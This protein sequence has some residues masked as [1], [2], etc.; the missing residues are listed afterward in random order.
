MT[1]HGTLL[2]KGKKSIKR[3]SAHDQKGSRDNLRAKYTE[4][5]SEVK[6]SIKQIKRSGRRTLLM[7]QK[8][9][10]RANNNK[11]YLHDHNKV[12]QY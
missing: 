4:K 11:L 8:K 10:Q 5:D 7:K 2:T 3:F 9:L 6:R 1:N 12:L